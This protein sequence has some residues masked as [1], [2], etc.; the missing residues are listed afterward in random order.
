MNASATNAAAEASERDGVRYERRDGVAQVT[1][2]RPPVN[3]LGRGMVEALWQVLERV[4]ADP[5][6]VVLHLRG[7]GRCFSA[8]ADLDEM[9]AAIGGRGGADAQVAFVRR[10]Q[11]LFDRLEALPT[12]TLAEI[13]GHALGGGLE[14]AL[15]C[16]LR[17]GAREV[18]VGLP[19]LS[20]GLV[21][22]G[23]GTQRLVRVCGG[24]LARRLILGAETIDGATAADMGLLHWVL[25]APELAARAAEI[26]DRLARLPRAAVAAAKACIGLAD[27]GDGAGF[28]AELGATRQLLAEPETRRRLT[29]FLDMDR[30][31]ARPD[32]SPKA[33]V[34]R[35]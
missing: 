28:E 25:P 3:A 17:L 23:G 12:V 26:A 30:V 32:P 11:A 35:P 14:L 6:V 16:D 34:G 29:A 8:G 22:G 20:L 15:A 7:E 10:L 21:P 18:R 9:R 33:E 4:Q 2:D 24:A 5:R 31:Q 13:G 27:R 1:L 19:E